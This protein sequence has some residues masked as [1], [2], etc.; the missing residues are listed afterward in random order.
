MN[1]EELYY[2][3]DDQELACL[4]K[5]YLERMG[6]R[7]S[8]FHTAASLKA[9]LEQRLPQ[10]VLA[11]WNLPDGTGLQLCRHIRS[12]WEHL[13]VLLITVR[14][15]PRDMVEGLEK[16]ADD[17]I[18]KPFPP[19]VLHSRLRAV[20]R[21]SRGYGGQTGPLSCGSIL[22]D[23]EK[24]KV[25]CQGREVSLSQPE[26]QLLL[27]LMTHQGQTLTRQRLLEQIWDQNGCFVNDNTL[28]VTVKRLREK[29]H[30]PSCLKTVRSFGYRMEEEAFEMGHADG[31]NECSNTL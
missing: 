28:T 22:L 7:V 1:C 19:E 26:Y 11:D 2:A 13:P 27:L 16:G 9:A 12:R 17:Y 4:V 8:C 20:L 18:T 10:A 23:Q 31:G 30:N 24:M 15:D 3:E 21:R 29:L 25:T 6:W 14:D 5:E